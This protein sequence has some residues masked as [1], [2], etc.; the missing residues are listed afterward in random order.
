MSPTLRHC[1]RSASNALA[2]CVKRVHAA[3]RTCYRQTGAACADGS[4]GALAIGK[5]TAS[6]VHA[7]QT[8]QC[9]TATTVAGAYGAQ[10]GPADLAARLGTACRQQA[11]SLVARTFGGPH[12]AVLNAAP[13]DTKACLDATYFQAEKL[14]SA[15]LKAQRSCIGKA[16]AGGAC[17][18]AGT[19]AAIAAAT[20]KAE[21]AIAAH[22]T[23]L[24]T[25]VG[26][27]PAQ[28]LARTAAQARC[29]TATASID[30]GPL[31]LDCGPRS[32]IP[33]PPRGQWVQVVL[34][35]ATWGTRCGDGSSYAFWLRLAPAG[36]PLGK[37]VTDMQ[38]GGVC[39]FESQCTSVPARLFNALDDDQPDG[40]YLSTNPA[41]NPFSDRTM[42]FMPYCT[43]DVHIGG[44][45]TSVFP[46]LTVHRFG[47]VNARAALSYLRDVLWAAM[48]ADEP[49]GWQPDD[50]EVFFAGESAGGFGV[51]Y[52]YHWML[53]DLGWP[54][55]TAVPDSALA[56]DNGTPLSVASLGLLV[57]GTANP[58][59]WNVKT[60]LPPYCLAGNCG[61]GPV[62][63]TATSPRLTGP[64]QQILN[65]SN[66]VDDGQVGTTFFST[67]PQWVNAMR[68]AYCSMKGTPG[69][70]YYLPGIPTPIHTMLRDDDRFTGMAADGVTVR[71]FVSAAMAN[72]AS[73]VDRVDA[74]AAID[75]AYPGVLPFAC[76]VD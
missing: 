24:E 50:L 3:T 13:D 39:V 61:V 1:E 41:V 9:A 32:G 7:L 44:G 20:A 76:A 62:I 29:A 48:D 63:Q 57:S 10:T 58:F 6:I 5:A 68:T 65:L 47:A 36:Q 56:L 34:D 17:D 42:L 23:A 14:G 66:Q 49:G 12:A 69:I 18:V 27:T 21:T 15:I 46:S 2:T 38:G 51:E 26:L 75:A 64:F 40:G 8:S 43:Q 45:S 73:V 72:P 70:H 31:A 35:E 25:A 71:D 4:P 60:T 19:N 59:G 16:H 67:T 37:I 55:T 22:C 28:L 11:T 54:K 30:T 33:V 52:N 74:G 53:D